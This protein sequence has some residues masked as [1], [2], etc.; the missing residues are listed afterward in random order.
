[1]SFDWEEYI[2]LA[3]FLHGYGGSSFTQ[4]A[5]FRCATSRAYYAAFCYARNYARD[6]HGFSLTHR[7]RD[8]ELVRNHFRSRGMSDIASKLDELRQWRNICDYD[9]T[10]FSN[11]PSLVA[12]AIAEAQAI[13]NN[14]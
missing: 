6:Q 9:D 4:E 8:H 1:M 14:L 2:S 12:S 3:L 13:I 10:I 7:P 5:A 11:I